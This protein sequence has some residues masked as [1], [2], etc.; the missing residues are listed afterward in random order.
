LYYDAGIASSI[1]GSN[2]YD[3]SNN[4]KNGTLTAAGMY[5]SSINGGVFTFNGTNQILSTPVTPNTSISSYTIQMAFYNTSTYD[6]WNR[7]IFTAFSNP[8]GLYVG[9]RL[10]DSPGQSGMHM[11]T[12]GNIA[13]TIGT[14]STFAINTWYILTAVATSTNVKIYLNGN[15]TPLATSTTG[16]DGNANTLKIG[17]SGYDANWWLGYIGNTLY[18]NIA[19]NTTQITQNYNALKGRFGLT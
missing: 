10:I 15:T 18:Y 4:G 6:T 8:P 13:T 19:L 2:V 11:Y 1:T 3:L 14:T 12:S 16:A 7:G 17:Q 5:N 9:T